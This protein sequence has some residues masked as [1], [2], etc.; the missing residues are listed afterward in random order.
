MKKAY[1]K[2]EQRVVVLQHKTQILQTSMTGLSNNVGL[3]YGGGGNGPARA[4]ARQY[5]DIDWDE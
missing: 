4:R 2:P 3:N 1:M 5:G